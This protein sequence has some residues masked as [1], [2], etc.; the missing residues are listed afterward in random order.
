MADCGGKFQLRNWKF[1]RM[2]CTS[3]EE[4]SWLASKSAVV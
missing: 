4:T 3:G 1:S 2:S